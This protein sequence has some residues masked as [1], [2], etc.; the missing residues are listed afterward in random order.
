MPDLPS[1]KRPQ[2]VQGMFTHIAPH[3]DLMNQLMTAGQDSRW[4]QEVIRRAGINSKSIV[5]DI[6]AGTGDL[7]REALR[8]APGCQVIAADFTL[9]MMQHGK[10]HQHGGDATPEWSAA[11]AVQLP[12]PDCT[13]DAV[14]SGFLLRNVSDLMQALGEQKRVLKPGGTIVVLDTTPPARNLIS[15]LIGF[16]FHTVIPLLGKILAGNSQAYTYLPESTEGFLEAEMLAGRLVLAGFGQVG[17]RRLML[18]TIAIHW[19]VCK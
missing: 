8:Q 5:L 9:A 1:S 17:F 10:T 11:D 18:G 4:R 13:F 19:G 6:G 2:D 14:I 7:S 16:Y 3:Y 12:F 15:P